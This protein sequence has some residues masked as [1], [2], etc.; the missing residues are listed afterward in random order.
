MTSNSRSVFKRLLTPLLA[1]FLLA[2]CGGDSGDAPAA[3]QDT[4]PAVRGTWRSRSPLPTARQ[5][6]P[7]AFLG[8]RIYT[9][10]GMDSQ[11]NALATMEIYDPVTD[12]WETGPSLPE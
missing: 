4:N 9:P 3:S 12:V 10:G 2:G 7:S 5:E 11:G 8:G 6:M 1:V